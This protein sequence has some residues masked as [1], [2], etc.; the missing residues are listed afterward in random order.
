MRD[1]ER[2]AEQISDADFNTFLGNIDGLDRSL[3]AVFRSSSLSNLLVKKLMLY[4]S[5]EGVLGNTYNFTDPKNLF[6]LH[7]LSG[8]FLDEYTR[9]IEASSYRDF[10]SS[11]R[12]RCLLSRSKMKFKIP[13]FM[14]GTT[15]IETCIGHDQNVSPLSFT[16]KGDVTKEVSGMSLVK[17]WN[18]LEVLESMAT[19]NSNE[20]RQC[21][22]ASMRRLILA[23]E[24]NLKWSVS[25]LPSEVGL[26][27]YY[28]SSTHDLAGL[29]EVLNRASFLN[30]QK[31]LSEKKSLVDFMCKITAE[32][33]Y[34]WSTCAAAEIDG[35]PQNALPGRTLTRQE[36]RNK[37]SQIS[38]GIYEEIIL[39]KCLT[40]STIALSRTEIF[41]KE[42]LKELAV[43]LGL[44]FVDSSKKSSSTS[45]TKEKWK[46]ESKGNDWKSN[47]WK[48]EGYGPSK[49]NDWSGKD[50]QWKERDETPYSAGNPKFKNDPWGQ[51]SSERCRF[52]GIDVRYR[53]GPDGE[54]VPVETHLLLRCK[55]MH[56]E[57]KCR[58]GHSKRD[59]EYCASQEY[60]E[61]RM[62]QREL[63]VEKLGYNL[64]DLRK[65]SLE[66]FHKTARL[67]KNIEKKDGD[68][69]K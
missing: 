31:I 46:D 17:R 8:R 42:V 47:D 63:L 30:K 69:K 26:C 24:I 28:A 10:L 59:K 58:F 21:H 9:S 56:D 16:S 36:F 57:G 61:A 50:K 68:D 48:K 51:S 6:N 27:L 29:I 22:C 19:C 37:Q 15:V 65:N 67:E 11:F 23:N 32:L 44:E 62:S 20:V 55:N 53:P 64:D 34:L 25:D 4:L 18:L 12:E 54:P 66:R 38:M 1:I 39:E 45:S 2:V 7:G 40:P 35:I 49:G 33:L 43:E 14:R 41:D 13:S 5:N 60:K 3:G 52:G